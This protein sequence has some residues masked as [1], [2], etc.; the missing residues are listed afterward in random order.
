MFH[1]SSYKP[2]ARSYN[3]ACE[4]IDHFMKNGRFLSGAWFHMGERLPCDRTAPPNGSGTLLP[5]SIKEAELARPVFPN[6]IRVTDITN[7]CAAQFDGRDNYHQIAEWP[8][9]L[10]DYTVKGTRFEPTCRMGLGPSCSRKSRL[11]LAVF[12]VCMPLG[13]GSKMRANALG[14][15]DP[16]SSVYYICP[17]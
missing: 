13:N 11:R 7:T 5:S 1:P 12:S 16:C 8:S 6:Y 15:V 4:N 10:G 14:S 17:S 2:D 9:K 3:V